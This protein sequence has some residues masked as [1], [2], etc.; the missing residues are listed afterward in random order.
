MSEN[1]K[2][3]K[4]IIAVY[5]DDSGVVISQ[6]QYAE[7]HGETQVS[8]RH[9]GSGHVLPKSAGKKKNKQKQ[10]TE[11]LHKLSAAIET[12]KKHKPPKL[13]QCSVCKVLIKPSKLQKH[14][15]SVHSTKSETTHKRAGYMNLEGEFTNCPIC[16][17]LIKLEDGENHF[18]KAHPRE[19][20]LEYANLAQCPL[21]KHRT[22]YNVLFVHIQV[23][24]PEKNPKLVMAEYNREHKKRYKEE[25]IEKEMGQLVS[26]YEKL[27]QSHDEPRDAGKYLGFMIRENGR[28]GSLP[29]HDNYS[30]ESNSE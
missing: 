12:A 28:F 3:V 23:S 4:P 9:Y 22:Q 27:K 25:K 18:A 29:L 2:P 13:I 21:C 10:N 14:L 30:D 17:S 7:L 15:A 24:H 19:N 20:F 8:N 26:E 1:E 16:K 6:K 11:K 5:T